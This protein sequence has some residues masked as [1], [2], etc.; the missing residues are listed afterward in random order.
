MIGSRKV[1]GR[2]RGCQEEPRKSVVEQSAERLACMSLICE[3][4]CAHAANALAL[5]Q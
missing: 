4:L 1:R 3:R 5:R 2:G